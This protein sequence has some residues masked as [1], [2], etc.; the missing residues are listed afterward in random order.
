MPF[1][2]H[3]FFFSTGFSVVP[4][5]L[6]KYEPSSGTQMLEHNSSSSSVAQIGVAQLR[7]NPCFRF[8]F[9]GISLGCSSVDAPC[10]F[11]V[12]ALQWNGVNEVAQGNTRFEIAA[13]PDPSRC[14]LSHRTLDPAAV[15][16]FSN[17]TAINITLVK[18]DN[19]QTWWADDLQIA[20]ADDECAAAECRARVPNKIMTPLPGSLAS[21]AKRALRWAVRG[22]AMVRH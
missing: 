16:S 13:C 18:A 22:P 6:G 1:P 10:V 3:R 15:G 12:T 8:N 5:P 4:P 11:D 17:L 21:K 14:A 19:L 7:G 20:W 2:Y 9:Q